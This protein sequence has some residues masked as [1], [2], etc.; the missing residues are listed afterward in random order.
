[1]T[2]SLFLLWDKLT[3]LYYRKSCIVLNCLIK[4]WMGCYSP[5]CLCMSVNGKAAQST[6]WTNFV[7]LLWLIWT[8]IRAP[9]P[10]SAC[11]AN[12]AV[13]S[14]V[15]VRKLKPQAQLVAPT[16]KQMLIAKPAPPD[17][18]LKGQDFE[19]IYFILY[20]EERSMDPPK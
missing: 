10:P 2:I 19:G 13:S 11:R 17:A 18:C 4:I 14:K 7:W 15:T 8:Q 5:N 6:T 16:L 12:Q 20:E 9:K 1:M 3:L